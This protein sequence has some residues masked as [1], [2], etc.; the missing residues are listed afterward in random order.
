[1]AE[2][3]IRLAGLLDEAAEFEHNVLCQY[4]FAAFSMKRHPDEGGVTW[5]QLEMMRRW[6]AS[7]LSIGRQEMEHLGLVTNLLTAIGEAPN[8]RRPNY[9]LESRYYPVHVPSRLEPFNPETVLRFVLFEKP[10]VTSPG[11]QERLEQAILTL[12]QSGCQLSSDGDV[13]SRW[14]SHSVAKLYLEIRNLF[15]ALCSEIG[16]DVLFIGPRSAQFTTTEIIPV[17]LRGISIPPNTPIYDVLISA[18]TS[19][20]SALK[21]IDQIVMEGEGAPEERSQSHFGIFLQMFRDLTTELTRDPGFEPG[22]RVVSN[23]RTK[24][25]E[26]EESPPR[27][28]VTYVSN[29]DTNRVS[30][31]FDQAYEAMVILLMRYFGHTDESRAEIGGIQQAV[32]FPLMTAVIRPLGEILTQLPAH[33]DPSQGT[34]G[35]SFDFGRRPS[36]LP[37]RR[38]A[39]GVLALQLQLLA[40]MAGELR[41]REVY[42]APIRDRLSL[43]YENAARIAINFDA[44]MAVESR[45]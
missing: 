44:A 13:L 43:L 31:L 42:P 25:H 28:D 32:F 40:Q 22:R 17:P 34:A 24:Y 35:P 27:Q 19:E 36:L 26:D 12:G 39:W 4:L 11:S 41:E 14:H 45:P 15:M 18:V 1:M 33:D 3:R 30:E 37:H 6:E 9:P 5:S 38:A 7:L 8:F 29:K 20:G 2:K 16:P 21:V 10:R 23:P